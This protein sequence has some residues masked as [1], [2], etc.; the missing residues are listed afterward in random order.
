LIASGLV[1][2]ADDRDRVCNLR[3]ICAQANAGDARNGCDE[4]NHQ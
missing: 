3:A 4:A 2:V 1:L